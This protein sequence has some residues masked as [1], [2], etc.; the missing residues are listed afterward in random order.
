MADHERES[1]SEDMKETLKI[2]FGVAFVVA[3]LFFMIGAFVQFVP[4]AWLSMEYIRMYPMLIG[5][6]MFI[7]IF[8]MMVVAKTLISWMIDHDF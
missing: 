8:V 5:V 4:R 1:K 3:V 6:Y 7:A 2:A